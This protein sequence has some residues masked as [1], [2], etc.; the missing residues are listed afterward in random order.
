MNKSELITE[1][2]DRTGIDRV[3]VATVVEAFLTVVKETVTDRKDSV[4]LR[5]FGTFLLKYRAATTG[6]N[7]QKNTTIDIP[8]RYT[9]TFR[10]AKEFLEGAE[11]G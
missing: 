7:I 3:Y 6:R 5:G 10:P 8:A 2:V 4:T 9:P 11:E 1:I